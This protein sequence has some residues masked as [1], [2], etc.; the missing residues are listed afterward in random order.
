MAVEAES[1]LTRVFG[2]LFQHFLVECGLR[3]SRGSGEDEEL[4][5]GEDA[6]DVEQEQFDFAGAGGGRE[7]G[8]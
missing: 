3:T 5:V 8:H 1:G 7:L 2:G 4:A 6:V